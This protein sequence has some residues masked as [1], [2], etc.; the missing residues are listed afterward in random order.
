MFSYFQFFQC[1]LD[2]VDEDCF[3][4]TLSA[5]NISNFEISNIIF[6]SIS[7]YYFS[8]FHAWSALQFNTLHSMKTFRSEV[9][10]IAITDP[11]DKIKKLKGLKKVISAPTSRVHNQGYTRVLFI[12]S[13]NT[14][15]ANESHFVKP[16]TKYRNFI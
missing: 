6:I 3:I 2:V 1:R 8:S 7:R 5:E 15:F 11:K 12:I 9:T 10:K 14:E 16:S 4:N 13:N